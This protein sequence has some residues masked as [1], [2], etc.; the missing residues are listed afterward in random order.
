MGRPS[1]DDVLLEF[2]RVLFWKRMSKMLAGLPVLLVLGGLLA[3][4]LS[5]LSDIT[6][7]LSSHMIETRNC[8]TVYLS[9]N[10]ESELALHRH[11]ADQLYPTDY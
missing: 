11:E 10:S 6:F 7:G 3:S 8:S 4:W 2:D 9:N 5:V 1:K